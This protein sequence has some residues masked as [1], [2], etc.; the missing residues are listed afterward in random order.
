MNYEEKR[1]MDR[2]SMELPAWISVVDESGKTRGFE[3]ITKN[4]CAGGAYLQ[5]ERPLMVGTD[6]EMSLI[7]PLDNLPNLGKR[8]SRIEVS[9]KVVR[10]ELQGFAVCFDK[11][12]Q[13]SRVTS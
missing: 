3:F 8:R 11:K 6:I 13:I 10:S 2:F 7:L 12:H 9:G 5:T 4:I 1:K